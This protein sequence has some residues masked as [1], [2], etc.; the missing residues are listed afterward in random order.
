MCRLQLAP[1]HFCVMA[2]VSEGGDHDNLVDLL[3][4]E[5]VKKS[6]GRAREFVDSQ[7]YV[8]HMVGR[9]FECPVICCHVA[10]IGL[11]NSSHAADESRS[12]K[13]RQS[14][15][16]LQS[17]YLIFRG[18]RPIR[19]CRTR[20]SCGMACTS[21]ETMRRTKGAVSR[22]KKIQEFWRLANIFLLVS[23]HHF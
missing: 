20:R 14:G 10:H 5:A 17:T 21:L 12:V 8:Q 7:M 4:A 15:Q 3:L 18:C 13:V 19:R 11:N 23:L 6:L 22:S 2:V 1:L 9:L 16:E